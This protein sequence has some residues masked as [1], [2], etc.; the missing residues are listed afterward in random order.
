MRQAFHAGRTAQADEDYFARGDGSLLPISWLITP[1]DIGD[2]GAGTLVLFHTV[3]H[4]PE[5]PPP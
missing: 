3:E 2:D 5:P 1:Y 4:T